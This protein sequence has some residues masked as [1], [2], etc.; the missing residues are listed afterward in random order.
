[1]GEFTLLRQAVMHQKFRS[2]STATS[3]VYALCCQKMKDKN[4]FLDN[5]PSNYA[6]FLYLLFA[7]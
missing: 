2:A 1:M 6:N 5:K 3:Q 4:Y 7:F